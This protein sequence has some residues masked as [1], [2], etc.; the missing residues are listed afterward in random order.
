MID[1]DAT[2]TDM[3]AGIQWQPEHFNSRFSDLA[4]E[5]VYESPQCHLSF[6]WR[7]S[8]PGIVPR[9]FCRTPLLSVSP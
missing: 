4:D 3:L 7:P 5:R 2:L 8:E 6:Q 1:F 9:L